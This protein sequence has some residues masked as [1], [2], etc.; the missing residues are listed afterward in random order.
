MNQSDCSVTLRRHD[1]DALR[2]FAMFLGIVLH[3]A[4]S[5]TGFPWPVED[6]SSNPI[7]QLLF[8]AIHG[9]RMPLF[10]LL[11]GLFTMMLWRRR[12][13]VALLKQRT[14]RIFIPFILGIV[15][16]IPA[17]HWASFIAHEWSI[18]HKDSPHETEPGWL[19]S[20]KA[21]D[22]RNIKVLL[23]NGADPQEVDITFGIPM[24]GWACLYGNEQIARLLIDSGADE[25][26]PDRNG[27]CPLHQS[28]FMGHFEI[29][30]LLIRSGAVP[31]IKGKRSETA[32]DSTRVDW[33]TTTFIAKALGISLPTQEELEGG[34]AECRQLL[35]KYFVHETELTVEVLNSRW[36]LNHLRKRYSEF[37][38]SDRFMIHLNAHSQPFHLI[39]TGV[40]GHLWFLWFLYWFVILFS[41]IACLIKNLSFPKLSHILILSPIRW[42]WLVPLTMIPQ[43]F[44]G[45]FAPSFGPDT[46]MSILPPPHLFTY[47]GIFFFF[48]ALSYD[49][50]NDKQ[51][52]TW[53]KLGIPLALLVALPLALVTIGDTFLSGLLQ[54]IYAWAMTFGMIGMFRALVTGENKWIRYL[55]DS[56]YWSYLVHL[57]ILILVQAWVQ[58]WDMPALVKFAIVCSVTSALLLIS[59]HTLVRYRWLGRLLNGPRTRPTKVSVTF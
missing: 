51:L 53:W 31:T 26:G 6:R 22:W 52:G 11:S 44:M 42:L 36:G 56:A 21:S 30:D 15:T 34:R 49:C 5:F 57:P 50:D 39:M 24:L 23:E 33:K 18:Q 28:A 9:F 8:C 16:L 45:C 35:K 38:V 7:F 58:K 29:V 47:Y 37:L 19:Q 40:F 20:L 48:G 27:N 25:N 1:L 3:S 55:S 2:A 10:F 4:L 46:S 59:Y 13:V 54:V 17:L 32:I 41:L 43:M 14:L 12:G